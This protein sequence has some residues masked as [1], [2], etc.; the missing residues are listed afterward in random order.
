MRIRV[1]N[2]DREM[3]SP[4]MALLLTAGLFVLMGFLFRYEPPKGRSGGHRSGQI[5]L[6]RL[7]AADTRTT[8]WLAIHDP[9]RIARGGAF[10]APVPRTP[11]AD[12]VKPEPRLILPAPRIVEPAALPVG[13][14]PPDAPPVTGELSAA[15]VYPALAPENYPRVTING[16]KWN[17]ALPETLIKL[18]AAVN[19]G[20]AELRFSQ[21]ILPGEIRKSVALSSGNVRVD[22]ELIAHFDRRRFADLPVK[23]RVVWDASGERA[24]EETER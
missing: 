8:K 24:G 11:P 10:P 13:S 6:L 4:A 22:R 1:N 14:L 9:T 17:S 7:N 21:G 5:A 3:H 19:A 15:P 12:A 2:P 18:A 23:I 16:V 20:T